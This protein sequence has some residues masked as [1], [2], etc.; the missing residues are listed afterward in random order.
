MY[1]KH[2]KPYP[3]ITSRALTMRVAGCHDSIGAWH[4]TREA[5]HPP[6]HEAGLTNGTKSVS[7][8]DDRSTDEPA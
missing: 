1:V 2:V 5:N 6:L 8:D 7:W 4:C 3:P